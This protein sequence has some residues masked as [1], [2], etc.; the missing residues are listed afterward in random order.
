MRGGFISVKVPGQSVMWETKGQELEGTGHILSQTQRENEC[1][2][3]TYL[4]A[5]GSVFYYLDSSGL[6]T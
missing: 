6:L 2:H 4:L 1:L 5:L 3:F